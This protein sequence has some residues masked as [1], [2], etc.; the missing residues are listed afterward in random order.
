MGHMLEY[1]S[2]YQLP[3]RGAQGLLLCGAFQES[4][5]LWN[6]DMTMKGT[7]NMITNGSKFLYQSLRQIQH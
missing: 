5:I 6:F 1:G 2:R 4:P 3:G 7:F